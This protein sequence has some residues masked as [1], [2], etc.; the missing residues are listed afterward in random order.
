[1]ANLQALAETLT[2]Q[3][4]WVKFKFNATPGTDNWGWRYLTSCILVGGSLE[5]NT[6]GAAAELF[7]AYPTPK[8]LAGA[9]V[10]SVAA[11]I[12]AHG[13]RFHGPKAKYITKTAA[14]VAAKHKG[15]VPNTRE[16]LEALPGVGRHVASVVLATVYGQNEFAV[17]V[18]V[19]RIAERFGVAGDDLQIENTIRA[20]VKPKL[21]GHFSRSF[22]DFGQTLCAATPNC[23]G[24]K[25]KEFGC[26]EK[27]SA[28]VKVSK[29]AVKDIENYITAK[30]KEKDVVE[31]MF[32]KKEAADS[33]SCTV[34]ISAHK[35]S[36]S[37]KG[38]RF[39]R[40]CKHIE[41]AKDL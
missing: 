12:K 1:M 15:K 28:S 10:E 5:T 41:M 21:W 24:C 9:D 37:C 31:I 8:A 23:V 2:A 6:L 32:I 38:F 33:G 35:Y 14:V 26:G 34:K 17:D 27:I 16:Q 29:P 18:H 30:V 3:H 36:C 4:K 19:R 20:S 22:V 7:A 25:V 39:Q 40:K 13:V 11:I